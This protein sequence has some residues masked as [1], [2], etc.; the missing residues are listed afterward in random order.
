M[1]KTVLRRTLVSGMVLAAT[2]F[3]YACTSCF[4]PHV[5]GNYADASGGFKLELK[6]EGKATLTALNDTTACT[7]KVDG[8][9]LTVTCEN[10]VLN[11]NIQDDGSLAPPSMSLIGPLHKVK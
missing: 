3:F 9:Q 1:G 7:Y 6:S 11:F 5:E 4:G 8:K 10:Q 2:L